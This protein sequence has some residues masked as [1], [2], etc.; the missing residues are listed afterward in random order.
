MN[1]DDA[2]VLVPKNEYIGGL[3]ISINNPTYESRG[4]AGEVAT[5]YGNYPATNA[6]T[7]SGSDQT[8]GACEDS[9]GGRVIWFNYNA[10]GAHGIYCYVKSIDKTYKVLMS[11][12]VSGGLG[13]TSS[14]FIHSS[15]VIGDILYWVQDG[16]P[17]KRINIMSGMKAY[18]SDTYTSSATAYDISSQLNQSVITLIR[19]PPMYPLTVAKNVD[20]TV[21]KDFIKE[22]AFQFAYRF[23]YVDGETSVI[24]T[25]SALMNYNYSADTY[26]YITITIPTTQKIQQ[27][28]QYIEVICKN[29]ITNISSIIK[30]YNRDIDSAS[31][32]SHNSGTA[33]N[34]RFYNDVAGAIIDSD[35]AVK[36]FDRIP[37][38]SKTMCIAKDR[39]MLGNNIY[40]YDTPTATS[41]ST[42]VTIVSPSGSVTFNWFKVDL[43]TDSSHTV[44][45]TRYYLDLT[46]ASGTPGYYSYSPYTTN[47]GPF[48]T[49]AIPYASLVY[50][51]SGPSAWGTLIKQWYG[52]VGSSLVSSVPGSPS[53]ANSQIFK[54]AS[55]Y[56]LGVVFYDES[57]RRCGVVYKGSET[58]IPDRT[59]T[60][61]GFSTSI[62]WALTPG[63]GEVPSWAKYYNIVMTKNSRTNFF[64][65]GKATS[66]R[67][68]TKDATTGSYDMSP[69]TMGSTAWALAIDISPLS[70]LGLGYNYQSGDICKIYP[71]TGTAV[72]LKVKDVFANYVLVDLYNVTATD[73]IYEIYSTKLSESTDIFYQLGSMYSITSGDYSV[74]SGSINGDCYC[75]QRTGPYYVEAMSPLD[76]YWINWNNIGSSANTVIYSKTS[77]KKT[78][79]AYSNV[80]NVGTGY[81]GMSEFDPSSFK[82]LPIEMS[83]ISRLIRA[84]KVQ[85]QGTIVLG[86][87]ETDTV[88]LYLEELHW[89]DNNGNATASLTSEFIGQINPLKGG[90]GTKFPE[91]AYQWEGMVTYFDHIKA[92]WIRYDTE[93]LNAISEIGKMHGYFVGLSKDAEYQLNNR[94]SYISSKPFRIL[95]GYDPT[96][97]NF[98]LSVSKSSF[99]SNG[100]EYTYSPISNTTSNVTTT[101]TS[102]IYK[103]S[104]TYSFKHFRAY[105]ITTTAT[106]KDPAT[107]T[108]LTG[109]FYPNAGTTSLDIITASAST[110]SCVVEEFV[111]SIT[112]PYNSQSAV[113]VWDNDLNKFITQYSFQPE[114]LTTI[115]NRPVS[116]NSG[117][118]YIHSQDAPNLR[119]Y[120]TYHDASSAFVHGDDGG[121]VKRY[122]T[123]SVEGDAPDWVFA[124]TSNPNSQETSMNQF[125]NWEG[126]IYTDILRDR[127]SPNTSGNFDF[128]GAFGDEISG[129]SAKFQVV[130]LQPSDEKVIKFVDIN[131][132]PSRGQR[133]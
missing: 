7:M 97:R 88:S 30:T 63:T 36:Q 28:V 13:F 115:D 98:L 118:M 76:K 65:Q 120:G 8:I 106:V 72:S 60:T 92:C 75:L 126:K 111:M 71:S 84:S 103:G 127:N 131:W 10:S 108:V 48:P 119:F 20:S 107:G 61:S 69:T 59:Y 5:V 33:I 38:E 58:V 32:T 121:S 50:V 18:V 86:I 95:G 44:Y 128:K 129:D 130:F 27:D 109:I 77:R 85:E 52:S 123:I 9:S 117:L 26:N 19:N 53:I 35:T 31:F 47:G 3:N 80:Y 6:L 43:W 94:S 54:S 41:L 64:V 56:K 29:T 132:S 101:L 2:D 67:Y 87:G 79:I 57:Y 62:N 51:V 1:T 74:F 83:S 122:R 24:S 49:S 40:G 116:F 42:T 114:W 93:G 89:F 4:R 11:A 17:P 102:G 73:I 14:A 55:T 90:Y 96:N 78:E 124:R 15:G 81:N 68:P 39:L 105:R 110:V 12:D 25:W 70:A 82:Q 23:R 125:L 16:Q 37:L 104:L 66:F 112:K 46:S 100:D 91:S 99:V 133:V 34:F 21:L 113:W 22:S 45:N